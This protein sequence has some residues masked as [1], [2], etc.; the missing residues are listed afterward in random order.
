MR[1]GASIR[2]SSL[3]LQSSSEEQPQSSR[4][5]Q[6]LFLTTQLDKPCLQRIVAVT[7]GHQEKKHVCPA[8]KKT[9]KLMTS[10]R[11]HQRYECGKE[12]QFGCPHCSYKAHQ[13]GSIKSHM[14]LRHPEHFMSSAAPW[15]ILQG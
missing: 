12:P 10:L 15:Q 1:D 7:F 6:T 4:S 2:L 13:K 11:N 8:C 14:F 3:P 5:S 9:Y